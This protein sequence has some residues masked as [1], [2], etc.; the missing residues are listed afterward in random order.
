MRKEAILTDGTAPRSYWLI[1]RDKSGQLD[2]FTFNLYGGEEV[3]PIFS[4]G[5]EAVEVLRLGMWTTGWRARKTTIE[6]LTSVLLGPCAGVRRIALDPWPDIDTDMMV[7]LIGMRREDF[8]RFLAGEG[9]IL[10]P[11]VINKEA[12][13]PTTHTGFCSS[14]VDTRVGAEKRVSLRRCRR[15]N[16]SNDSR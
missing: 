5:E 13:V 16:I 12:S 6:K 3:L 7:A 15:Q 1:E 11:V 2:V 10:G 4:S 14:T 9:K 8:V